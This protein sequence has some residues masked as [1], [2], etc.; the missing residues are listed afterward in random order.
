MK[1]SDYYAATING[2]FFLIAGGITLGLGIA[3]DT[4][5]LYVIG[6][7]FLIVGVICAMAVAES[8]PK[9]RR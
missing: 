4:W 1:R 2:I 6:V 7:P 8:A 9:A 5:T 3:S